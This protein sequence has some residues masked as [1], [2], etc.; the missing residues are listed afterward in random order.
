MTIAVTSPGGEAARPVSVPLE[1]AGAVG[2]WGWP[3]ILTIYVLT[4]FCALLL[5]F[6]VALIRPREPMAWLLLARVIRRVGY[7]CSV[8]TYWCCLP[9]V[10]ATP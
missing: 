2:P 6:A 1:S 5:G 4:Q 8:A 10:S 7:T 3:V 9:T